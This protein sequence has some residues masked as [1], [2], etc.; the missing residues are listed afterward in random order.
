MGVEGQLGQGPRL[1]FDVLSLG[2][3]GKPEEANK[4]G[5]EAPG[6]PSRHS[7]GLLR[8]PELNRAGRAKYSRAPSKTAHCR[9]QTAPALGQSQAY[10]SISKIQT[11]QV[12][13]Q[14]CKPN[15]TN[16]HLIEKGTGRASSWQDTAFGWSSAQHP[17][18]GT[19]ERPQEV[20]GS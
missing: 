14:R 19:T 20:L 8:H 18:V 13:H 7:L 15:Q 17:T 12:H 1:V 3:W 9:L 6:H 2:L 16:G 4:Y 11:L 10:P 5:Q